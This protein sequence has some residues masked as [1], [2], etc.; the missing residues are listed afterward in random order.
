MSMDELVRKGPEGVIW[1]CA[2]RV[3]SMETEK[4]YCRRFMHIVDSDIVRFE[5]QVIDDCAGYKALAEAGVRFGLLVFTCDAAKKRI[6][7]KVTPSL[8]PVSL[9]PE[10]VS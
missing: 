7:P 10:T 6:I 1:V 2:I 8:H 3:S 9:A 5:A 4:S